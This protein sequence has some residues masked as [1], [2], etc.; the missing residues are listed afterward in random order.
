MPWEIVNSISRYAI[1]KHLTSIRDI[2][3]PSKRNSIDYWIESKLS[4]YCYQNNILLKKREIMLQGSSRNIHHLEDRRIQR[5][6]SYIKKRV[7]SFFHIGEIINL[8]SNP[9][10]YAVNR[11]NAIN[12][13]GVSLNSQPDIIIEKGEKFRLIKFIIQDKSISDEY[14]IHDLIF[15][16]ALKNKFLP[17]DLSQFELIIYS[18]KGSGWDCARYSRP[19]NS[20]EI[21]LE[22]VKLD[23]LNFNDSIKTGN[24]KGIPHLSN[25]KSINYCKSCKHFDFCENNATIAKRPSHA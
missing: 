3:S 20:L 12:M 13:E 25:S 8:N 6:A 2:Q 22:N 7:K 17:N 1:I 21:L 5:L 16:W 24:A 4:E 23:V 19:E 18:W 10:W 15:L 11:F 14:S 9:N